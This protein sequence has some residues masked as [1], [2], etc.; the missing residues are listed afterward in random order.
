MRD[1]NE[2]FFNESPDF[3]SISSRLSARFL[4]EFIFS[5]T[6]WISFSPLSSSKKLSSLLSTGWTYPRDRDASYE[7]SY[8]SSSNKCIEN[9]HTK[10]RVECS[11]SH[12]NNR[13]TW[14]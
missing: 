9:Y 4:N 7:N 2:K 11:Q 5:N 14:H 1:I 8:L 13:D 6:D 12:Y 10:V 3:L